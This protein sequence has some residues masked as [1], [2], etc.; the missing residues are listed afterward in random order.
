M[1]INRSGGARKSSGRPPGEPKKAIGHR[2]LV[3]FH[4]QLVQY[5]KEKE[6]ELL[7]NENK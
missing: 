1:K 4:A 2:V 3:R 6:M 5:L 7:D